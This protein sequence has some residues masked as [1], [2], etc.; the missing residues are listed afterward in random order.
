MKSNNK[1][2]QNQ[3]YHPKVVVIELVKKHPFKFVYLMIAKFIHHS[4]GIQLIRD[5]FRVGRENII[6]KMP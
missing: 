1:K 6:F 4:N 5:P 2:L 3:L